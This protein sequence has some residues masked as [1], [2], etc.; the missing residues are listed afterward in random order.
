ML[1]KPVCVCAGYE[2]L[3]AAIVKSVILWN[4][5]SVLD[6]RFSLQQP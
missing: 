2:V 4:V 1:G 5:M 6:M 3:A